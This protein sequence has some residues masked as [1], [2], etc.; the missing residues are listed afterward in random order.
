MS[1]GFSGAQLLCKN[2]C[3]FYGNESWDGYCS[4]CFK[5][6]KESVLELK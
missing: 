5:R 6:A 1:L 3:G 2:K 4:L